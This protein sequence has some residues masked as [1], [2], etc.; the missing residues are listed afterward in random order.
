MNAVQLKLKI[1]QQTYLTIL[2]IAIWLDDVKPI[3][4]SQQFF[5]TPNVTPTATKCFIQTDQFQ[6]L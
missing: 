5:T 6:K 2:V 1:S 3:I 4:P